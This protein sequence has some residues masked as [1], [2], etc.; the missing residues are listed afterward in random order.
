MLKT[1]NFGFVSITRTRYLSTSCIHLQNRQPFALTDLP[2][3]FQK[4][5]LDHKINQQK[6][7]SR[8]KIFD[9]KINSQDFYRGIIQAVQVVSRKISKGD[10]EMNEISESLIRRIKVNYDLLSDE[11]K[12]RIVVKREDVNGYLLHF[13]EEEKKDNFFLIRFGIRLDCVPG[14]GE[15][16]QELIGDPIKQNEESLKYM[17]NLV[18]ADYRFERKYSRKFPSSW[19]IYDLNHYGFGNVS[20]IFQK[21]SIFERFFSKI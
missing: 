18:I 8:L 19:E 7:L 12:S 21:E 11:Q 16:L 1:F 14:V 4:N 2:I 6:L 9:P 15:K 17:Q 3:I 20:K 5:L 13:Y 10:F